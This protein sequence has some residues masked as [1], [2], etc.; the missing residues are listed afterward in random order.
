MKEERVLL[1][2]G[3]GEPAAMRIEA[4]KT[5]K[6]LMLSGTLP[7]KLAATFDQA[8]RALGGSQQ[9]ALRLAAIDLRIRFGHD[10]PF[11]AAVLRLNSFLPFAEATKRFLDS[12]ALGRGDPYQEW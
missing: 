12:S 7:L 10:I 8:T 3:I 1:S 2:L 4:G 11:S 9:H 5:A 6:P